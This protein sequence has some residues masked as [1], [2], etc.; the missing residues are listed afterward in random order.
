MSECGRVRESDVGLVSAFEREIV[1]ESEKEIT[2]AH[3]R[4]RERE[5]Q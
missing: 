1:V 3:A 4:E 2:R 5:R